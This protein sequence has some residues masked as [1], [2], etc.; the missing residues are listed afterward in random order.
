M[1]ELIN[2]VEARI[3]QAIIESNTDN[4][5]FALSMQTIDLL[6]RLLATLYNY[7]LQQ[8]VKQD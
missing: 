2:Q 5:L 3:A 7:K 1:D 8:N 4:N 6:T